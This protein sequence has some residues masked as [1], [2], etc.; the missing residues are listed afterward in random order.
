MKSLEGERQPRDLAEH[1]RCLFAIDAELAR[2]AGHARRGGRQF[3]RRVDAQRDPRA[4][5][6][7]NARQAARLVGRFEHDQ[8]A[9]YCGLCEFVIGLAGAGETQPIA[10]HAA[11]ECAGEFS[12]RCDIEAVHLAADVL[13]QRR[14]R[15]RLDC[16]Q[17]ADLAR[18]RGAQFGDVRVDAVARIE[19]TGRAEALHVLGQRHTA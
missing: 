14:Q 10:R 1:L 11:G 6:A 16:I 9:G 19:V 3:E 2:A 4:L 15:I 5:R 13:E 18:D 17:Q 8:R 12:A 7:G